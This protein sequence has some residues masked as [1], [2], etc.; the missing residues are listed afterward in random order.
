MHN[1]FSLD[2]KVKAYGG[3]L[4]VKAQQGP[5]RQ[6]LLLDANGLDIGSYSLLKAAGLRLSGKLG[7]N[8]EMT[9]DTG[10]RGCG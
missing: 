7:G 4:L 2:M 8:I 10:G 1:L 5:S 3:E 9:G 6:Y